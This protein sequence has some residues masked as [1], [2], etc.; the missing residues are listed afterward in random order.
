MLSLSVGA[1]WMWAAFLG[2]VLVMLAL[3]LGLFHRTEHVIRTR[4]ALAWSAVWI[5][6][7][8]AFCALV[9]HF[10]GARLG[11]EFLTAY[12]VEKALSVDNLFVFMALFSY[13]ALP[14][15]LEHRVLFWGVVGALVLRAV[16]ILVGGALLHAFH[17]IIYIFGA[18]LILTGIKLFFGHGVEVHPESNPM[19]R[20]FRRLVPSVADYRDRHFFVREGGRLLATPLFFVLIMVEMT[21]VLFAVDS[22]PAVFAISKDPFIVFTSNIF[23]ILGLR[24]LYFLL[25]GM[26]GR[27]RY[28]RYG[29][30]LVLV[31]VGLKMAVSELVE[32]PVLLSLG[33]IA[34]LIGGAI[35]ISLWKV[36]R[37]AST[38]S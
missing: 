12:V 13:F 33:V 18:F 22:I 4:E 36:P 23:A 2:F 9:W 21:D 30:A 14:R 32:V 17:W 3:D 19:L 29:L 28:L 24:A 5:G 25:A 37:D 7:A 20:L 26:L 6:L 8:M 34:L 11:L 10:A 16:F 35:G 27:F 31:F 1:P 15:Y 38:H